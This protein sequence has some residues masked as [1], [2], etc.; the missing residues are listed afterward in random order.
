VTLKFVIADL[1]ALS[2]SSSLQRNLE[3]Q[4]EP[5]TRRSTHRARDSVDALVLEPR[6]TLLPCNSSLDTAG[7][8]SDIIAPSRIALR[9]NSIRNEIAGQRDRIHVRRRSSPESGRNGSRVDTDSFVAVP[10]HAAYLASILP[11]LAP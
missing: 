11:H 6:E 4:M 7:L 5:L 10:S 9:Q 8:G 2:V 3:S 1:A